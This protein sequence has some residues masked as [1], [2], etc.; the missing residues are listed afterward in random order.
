MPS[1][2]IEI[3]E[4]FRARELLLLVADNEMAARLTTIDAK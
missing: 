3:F 2:K 4:K 1:N